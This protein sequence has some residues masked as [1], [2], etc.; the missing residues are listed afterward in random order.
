MMDLRSILIIVFIVGILIFSYNEIEGFRGRG[1]GG[2]RGR[3]GRGGG[4]GGG[5][6][7]GHRGAWGRGRKFRHNR[8]PGIRRYNRHQW[9]RGPRNMIYDGVPYYW[10]G[11]RPRPH[12]TI[13]NYF[14]SWLYTGQCRR[15]CGY[16]GNGVVG[17]INPTNL[18]DS[19]IFASDCYG[20]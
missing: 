10:G 19:C 18:P 6:A 14:P 3:A 13:Y 7:R 5:R 2:G 12:P 8:I 1:G 20:C 4:G 17:C 9:R 15:G 16:I 11:Y